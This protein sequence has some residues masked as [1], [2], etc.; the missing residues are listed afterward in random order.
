MKTFEKFIQRVNE[1]WKAEYLNTMQNLK[2]K[3]FSMPL[4]Y[5]AMSVQHI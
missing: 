2:G 5:V 1:A 3:I 4:A